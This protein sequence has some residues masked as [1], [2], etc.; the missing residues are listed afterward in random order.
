MATTAAARND[1]RA[2]RRRRCRSPPPRRPV[3]SSEQT[4][5][6]RSESATLEPA[7]NGQRK[8]TRCASCGHRRRRP[9]SRSSAAVVAPWSRSRC[10]LP[11]L[12]RTHARGAAVAAIPQLA[13]ANSAGVS[14]ALAAPAPPRRSARS[15]FPRLCGAE[16]GTLKPFHRVSPTAV[17]AVAYVTGIFMAAVD[18]QIVNVAL[19]TLGRVFHASIATAQWAVL[20]HVPSLAVLIPASGWIGD[21]LGTKRTFLVALGIFTLA[22]ALCGAAQSLDQL[23][24]AR[25]LQGV[26]GGVLT[27]TGTA[28]LFRAVPPERRARIT[29]LLVMPIL[30]GPA[31]APILGGVFTQ[32][33]SWRWVFFV[34]VPVGVVVFV[35]C[36][37]N[38]REHREQPHGG[39]DGRPVCAYNESNQ[40]DN[41]CKA[42]S[43]IRSEERR[44]G[45]ECRSR[46][47]PYH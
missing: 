19:P 30:I 43:V 1:G 12:G 25:V 46:W 35:F 16:H 42:R 15:P 32:D 40:P 24:V 45:K 34:N 20:G 37:I 8:E 13:R 11:G 39:F 28:M 18:L 21:R 38:L 41:S 27:P 36:A 31:S 5:L 10:G 29:R 3:R 33:L 4:H 7:A 47:S 14:N 23:I 44:V 26:G 9:C 6:S 17:V 2:R 22:S